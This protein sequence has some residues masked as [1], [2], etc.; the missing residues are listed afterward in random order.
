[1]HHA[2]IIGTGSYTPS[3][4]ITNDNLAE[5]LETND[6]WISSRTGIKERR[7]STGENTS[8]LAYQAAIRALEA[9]KMDSKNIDLIICATITPDSFMPSVACII[10]DKLGA[11]NAA[12]FD[13]TAACTGLIYAIVI[14][15]QFIRSG[16]YK[17]IL[18][19]G[20]ETIS[21]VLDW[22]DRSTC[23]LFGDGAG[24][25]LLSATKDENGVLTANL[26][27]DGSKQ[28]FLTCPAIPVFNPYVGLE[29]EE[30]KPKIEMQGQEVFKYAVRSVTDN[31]KTV[32]NK[33]GMT[34]E[35]IRYII[36]HQANRRIIEQAAKLGDIS[37]EKFYINLDHFGNTS[38]AS[39]GIA[40]D[41]LMRSNEL[42]PGDKLI[43]VGF[44]GGMTSGAV[45]I[46]I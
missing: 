17:N 23:V 10:Q 31:I 9:A 7:I 18:L 28:S 42:K 20:A 36:P 14:A 32:L 21:K 46:E 16:M 41:E 2:A 11:T 12:A 40:L 1:M 27:S 4:I 3:N 38:A 13:L 30:F 39:I 29:R 34:S 8:D 6:E 33:A 5:F 37:I 22:E 24:A 19:V 15:D 35:D 26:L 25:V 43:L 45:L 44:G